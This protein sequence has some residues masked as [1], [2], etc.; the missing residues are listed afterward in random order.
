MEV[1]HFWDNWAIKA[2]NLEVGY[3]RYF[4]ENWLADASLRYYT[5]SKALF[6][7]DNATTN[8]EYVSRNRQLSNFDDVGVGGKVTYT[9]KKEATYNVKLN[10]TYELTNYKY[11]DF[12]DLRTGDLY[13]FKANL[14][15]LYVSAT[16]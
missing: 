5:Q 6:Y 14:V 7:S 2:N 8:T 12:T 3:S 13:S 1:R 16:F 10:A 15:Q 4:G 9:L 11:H